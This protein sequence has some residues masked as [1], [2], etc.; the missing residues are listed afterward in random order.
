VGTAF[1]IYFPKDESG[2]PDSTGAGPSPVGGTET[3]LLVE[4]EPRVREVTARMLRAGGYRVLLAAD[5]PG[6]LE[7]VRAEKGPLHLLVSD[8]VMPGPGG[9]ETA[10]R[11]SEL[12]PGIRILYVSG[13]AD[14]TGEL[15]G[16]SEDGAEVLPK[17]FTAAAL[18][19]R[20]REALDRQG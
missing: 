7:R 19:A 11:V 6:A 1:E 5:C 13:Y 4:D 3:I 18:L 9:R 16:T 2:M 10:R 20:V 12:V 17:P 8:L 15:K 14:R